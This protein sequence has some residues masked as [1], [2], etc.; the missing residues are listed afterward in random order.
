MKGK[1]RRTRKKRKQKDKLFLSIMIPVTVIVLFITIGQKLTEHGNEE[2]AMGQQIVTPKDETIQPEPPKSM[3]EEAK[4][5]IPEP[6]K[7]EKPSPSPHKV[8]YLTFDDGPTEA[9]KELLDLLLQYEVKATFFMLDG[10]VKQ[11]PDLVKRMK[12]E[13][14]ALGIHGV[15][16]DRKKFYRSKDSVLSELDQAKR[17]IQ[18]ITGEIPKL[19]R[20]PYGSYPGMKPS[21][22]EAVAQAGYIL[23]DWN[24]DSND[25]KYR[26][27]RMIDT[28]I[29]QIQSLE[30]KNEAPIILMH[31]RPRT[32]KYVEELL[33]YLTEQG[34]NLEPLNETIEPIVF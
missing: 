15:S 11:H 22:K 5:E 27:H 19:I 2:L 29:S 7:K 20:T 10:N 32:V 1:M 26:N 28:T 18:D 16:H 33:A 12:E 13:G 14:H 31:D 9:T 25:W 30:K 3:V 8:A 34:Y 4:V 24:V 17:T 21:Y 23:W 6:T